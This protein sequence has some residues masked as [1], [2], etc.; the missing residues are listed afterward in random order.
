MFALIC[1]S[2]LS[3]HIF[4]MVYV[5]LRVV[6]DVCIVLFCV[7]VCV[8]LCVCLCLCVLLTYVLLVLSCI[9]FSVVRVFVAGVLGETW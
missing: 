5:A 4:V 2:S 6:C 1:P 3:F 7:C 9:V 8:P